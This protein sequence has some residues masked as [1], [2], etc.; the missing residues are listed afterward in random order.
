MMATTRSGRIA[1][2]RLLLTALTGATALSAA[3][4]V[5]A[6]NSA[7][8]EA[9]R[10]EV[11]QQLYDCRAIADPAE[12]LACYDRQVGALQSAVTA[13]DI[14]VVDREQVRQT[15]RGLFGLSLPNIGNI[16]GSGDPENAA[17]SDAVNELAATLR[18]V[19]RNESG[20]WIYTLD[21]D[22]VWIQTDASAPGR[23]PRPGQNVTIRRAALGS[24]MISVE[25]R[26]G[27]R[28]R[29]ER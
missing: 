17:D 18:A 27:V 7:A 4:P 5:A 29:R 1:G 16:F 21:N 24:F 11:L 2:A 6:Q 28:V 15:R 3:S 14:R 10:I 19:G 22:Q 23:G 25:G 8:S 26:P 9:P 20:R 13:Q 12:R